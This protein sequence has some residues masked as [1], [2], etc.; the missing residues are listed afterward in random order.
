GLRIV[1]DFETI[2]PPP[3][4]FPRDRNDRLW[5][6]P[7]PRWLSPQK[8]RGHG[9]SHKTAP[10]TG[11]TVPL[12]DMTRAPFRAPAILRRP[13]APPPQAG[14]E[15]SCRAGIPRRPAAQR[16]GRLVPGIE[17]LVSE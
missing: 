14:E 1:P 7:W 15:C 4:L 17:F 6:R 9:R 16:I 12:P 8:H 13:A 10:T 11:P 2:R 3:T 5:E